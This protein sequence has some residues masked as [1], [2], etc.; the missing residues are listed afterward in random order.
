MGKTRK[1]KGT[2]SQLEYKETEFKWHVKPVKCLNQKQ[3][4]FVRSIREKEITICSGPSGS[5][6]TY[7]ALWEALRLLEKKQFDQIVLVKSVTTVPGE[8]IGFMPG[9]MYEKMDPFIVSFTGNLDKLIGEDARKYLINSGK[10]KI[11]PLAFARGI[12][13]DHSIV[14]LDEVQNLPL[15]TF[16]TIITRIGTGSR[17]VIMGDYSQTDLKIKSKS[18]LQ[19]LLELFQ[20]DELV[21]TGTFGKEDCVRNPII[22]HLLDKLEILENKK[23]G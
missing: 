11:Q 5:G 2:K 8:E 6:K 1:I 14:I 12:N 20:E 18:C 13:I 19:K 3:K 15:D 22:P 16:K 17:Y 7:V 4:E 23:E 21:G 9:D 10:I